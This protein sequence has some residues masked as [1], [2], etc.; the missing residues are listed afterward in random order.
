MGSENR[1]RPQGVFVR[2]HDEERAWMDA[3]AKELGCT[4]AEL[5]RAIIFDRKPITVVPCS[6]GHVG[7]TSQH[8]DQVDGY[9]DQ[10]YRE[11]LEFEA[12]TAL[13]PGDIDIWLAR[14]NRLTTFRDWLRG[15]TG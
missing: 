14:G 6:K 15:R 12:A 2:M 4:A 7:C 8:R 9:R 3:R 1:A 10:R 5:A 13:L 11:E